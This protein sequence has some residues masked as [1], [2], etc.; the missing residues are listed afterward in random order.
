MDSHQWDA[1]LDPEVVPLFLE[2]HW[3]QARSLDSM[4]PLL[5]KHR[6]SMA[7]FDVLATLRNA[8][9]PHEMTPSAIQG[10]VVIT[11]GGLSKVMLQLDARGLVE[12]PR[13]KDD[14]R[15]KPVRLTPLGRQ[16]IETAMAEMIGVTGAWIKKALDAAEIRRLTKLLRKVAQTPVA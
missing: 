1:S 8:P 5:L 10:E 7:E 13:F 14:M 9:S 6:L 2:L 15:V 4:R 3:A 11:S 12:R 16:S